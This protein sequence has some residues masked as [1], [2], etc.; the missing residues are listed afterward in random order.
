MPLAYAKNALRK[1]REPEERHRTAE[2]GALELHIAKLEA[3]PPEASPVA[4]HNNP[5]ADDV[6]PVA[7]S[8]DA[9][10]AHMEDLLTE[11]ANWAD[12][13][14]LASQAQADQAAKLRQQ[15]QQAAK[16]ADTA[17]IEEK[18]PLDQQIADI[19]TRYNE[20]IA[21]L[22]N[23]DAGKISKS[24]SALGNLLSAWL[25]K[26]EVEKQE[27]ERIANEA[28]AKA[29]EE[30]IAARR[31][32]ESATDLSAMAE[33]E[34]LLAT[35]ETLQ[36]DAKAVAKEKV[37]A[38]GE[39]RAIGLKTRWKATMREGEGNQALR[40]YAKTQSQRVIAFLQMMADE[41]VKAGV[42]VIPGFDITSEKYV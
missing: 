10:R 20:Y 4:G 22:K 9:I 16:L 23:K 27:R 18:K 14:A 1:L 15:L 19:Q 32:I 29:Q 38:K 5:P 33:A 8:W 12:G 25:N 24:V 41:D 31:Q 42:R 35:A 7:M 36:R 30:A 40:H 6:E 3:N 26:L 34:D 2:I 17:R 21:P 28:A 39:T 37:Q 11:A 13:T